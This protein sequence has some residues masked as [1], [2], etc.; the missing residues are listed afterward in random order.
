MDLSLLMSKLG[1]NH[2]ELCFE[3][4]RKMAIVGTPDSAANLLDLQEAAC[5]RKHVVSASKSKIS[6]KCL[7]T[8][9]NGQFEK[10]PE[11]RS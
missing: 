11:M 7:G 3:V 8:D 2:A 4:V 1:G 5:I 6:Q 10:A 9:A